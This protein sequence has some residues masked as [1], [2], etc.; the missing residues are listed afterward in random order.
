M[1]AHTTEQHPSIETRLAEHRL[2]SKAKD[3]AQT[4]FMRRWVPIVAEL[5]RL[6][7]TWFNGACP[8]EPGI[9][10]LIGME[11]PFPESVIAEVSR[12]LIVKK[13]EAVFASEY[14]RREKREQPP[15]PNNANS[16]PEVDKVFR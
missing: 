13:Q 15:S 16:Q 6:V 7:I 11:T 8:N 1:N 3:H 9:R 10:R 14:A 12:Y 4:S 2:R 5:R